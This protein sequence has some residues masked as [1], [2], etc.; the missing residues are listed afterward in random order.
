MKDRN[1]TPISVRKAKKNALLLAFPSKD[2]FY[3]FKNSDKTISEQSIPGF[4]DFAH[5]A[6]LIKY[7]TEEAFIAFIENNTDSSTNAKCSDLS[8]EEIIDSIKGKMSVN[9]LVA[10]LNRYT[11]LFKLPKIHASM[12]TNLKKR[13][14]SNSPKKRAVLRMFAFWI[15]LNRPN[16][17]L[18][19][20]MLVNI[21]GNE[22]ETGETVKN[23]MGVRIDITFKGHEGIV[24]LEMVDWLK[25]EIP[26]CVEDLRLQN[27][28]F[29]A[30]QFHSATTAALEI[31]NHSA[32]SQDPWLYGQ[33]LRGCFAIAHQ[34]SMRWSLNEANIKKQNTILIAI[35]AGNFSELSAAIPHLLEKD[36]PGNPS[37]RVNE[38]AH[39]ITKITDIKV[40]FET[41]PIIS[42]LTPNTSIQIWPVKNFWPLYY[43][44]IPDLL[45][46]AMLPTDPER[47]RQFRHELHFSSNN[48]AFESSHKALSAIRQAPQNHQLLIEVAKVLQSRRMFAE[49]NNALSIILA[50]NPYHII[51]RVFRIQLL[52]NIGMC[53]QDYRVFDGYFNQAVEESRFILETNHIDDEVWSEIGLM[54][55]SKACYILKLVRQRK[56][57]K[58]GRDVEPNI[59]DF[60]EY[61]DK[62]QEC[63]QKGI[64]HSPHAQRSYFWIINL[65][66]MKNLILKDPRFC[67]SQHPIVDRDDISTATVVQHLAFLGWFKQGDVITPQTYSPNEIKSLIQHF[68]QVATKFKTSVHFRPFRPRMLY[69][70]AIVLWDVCPILTAGIATQV[71]EWLEEAKI[72]AKELSD[73]CLGALSIVAWHTQIQNPSH[74]ID[75]IDRSIEAIYKTLEDEIKEDENHVIDKKKTNGL[76]LFTMHF[77]ET[78]DTLPILTS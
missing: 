69:S 20:T 19:Y 54:Y 9:A 78:V 27:T 46:E 8:F 68:R 12:I 55:A 41:E 50:S 44:I 49:A 61:I 43:D 2:E 26:K 52:I 6:E 18:D 57:E 34:I 38:F 14:K 13:F 3:Q 62:A 33:A 70:V 28:V 76:K 58:S 25:N 75:C 45:N 77:D 10:Q 60:I 48:H 47:Y 39:F 30:P 63:F 4:I 36:L 29:S 35:A 42:P 32:K 7:K 23:D 22:N 1:E 24:S 65:K 51:A 56:A 37:I 66:C 17:A 64:T 5:T 11:K 40:L 31:P 74:I 71:L 16:M 15:G 73:Q 67:M 59:E 72:E 21:R 53:Y